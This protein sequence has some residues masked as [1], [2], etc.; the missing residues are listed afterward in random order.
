MD[1]FRHF[2]TVISAFLLAHIVGE[3]NGK[4]FEDRDVPFSMREGR[5][6]DVL[7]QSI[8]VASSHCFI[9]DTV[10]P[11]LCGPH[12]KQTPSISWTPA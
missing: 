7:A 3:Y 10:K 2:L 4:V 6:Q 8:Q 11:L 5:S 9:I 1:A 12:I